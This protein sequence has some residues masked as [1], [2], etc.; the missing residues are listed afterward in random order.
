MA[1]GRQTRNTER[2]RRAV[3]DAATQVILEKGAAVTLAEVASVAG[4]SKSGLIHHFD[5]RDQLVIAVVED[6]HERFREAVLRHLDLSENYP[7]KMLRAYVRALCAGSADAVAARDFTAAPIWSGL[8]AIPAVAAV[9]KEH[10]AWW[11]EQ[12]ALDGLSTERI[13]I[14]R[15]AAEGIAIAVLYGEEDEASI[16]P[17]RRLLLE[18]ATDGTFPTPI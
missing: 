18:L 14:V 1:E 4:V 9:L 3:L 7:G 11:G 8:Y 12:F 16:A 5:N 17:A 2:T 6:A 13:L 10:G 15:R